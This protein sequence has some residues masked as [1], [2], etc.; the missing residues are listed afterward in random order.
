MAIYRSGEDY[1]EKIQMLNERLGYARSADIAAELNV[2]R[3]SVSIALKKL[4][5]DG[6]VV[7]DESGRITLTEAGQQV[8]DRIYG[9][10]KAIAA[11]L[12]KIGVCEE[13]AS[14]DA[15]RMEH[16]ISDETFAAIR[17]FIR[18]EQ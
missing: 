1:L 12:R 14:A 16:V 11:L 17:A 10:H 5:E 18:Q 9:R 6:F 15:C 4:R 7:M 2:S 13:T 8:A 3:P